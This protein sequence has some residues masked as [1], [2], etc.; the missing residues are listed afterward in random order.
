MLWHNTLQAPGLERHSYCFFLQ[1]SIGCVILGVLGFGFFY[2]RTELT[3][4]AAAEVSSFWQSSSEHPAYQGGASASASQPPTADT[5]TGPVLC[6][7]MKGFFIKASQ[8]FFKS[9]WPFLRRGKKHS[10]EAAK[11][12]CCPNVSANHVTCW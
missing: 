3:Q 7:R 11:C 5:A 8:C 12:C 9:G 4:E 1:E 10:E 6:P 2:L